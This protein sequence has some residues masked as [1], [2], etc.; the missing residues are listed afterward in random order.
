MYT[1]W[2]ST[3]RGEGRRESSGRAVVGDFFCLLSALRLT[4]TFAFGCVFCFPFV[5]IFF[6][7]AEKQPQQLYIL[8]MHFQFLWNGRAALC[9]FHTGYLTPHLLL[10]MHFIFTVSLCNHSLFFFSGG[11][12]TNDECDPTARSHKCWQI[13]IIG[14]TSIR[15][16]LSIITANSDGKCRNMACLGLVL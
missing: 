3:G 13:G 11:K 2:G 9:T 5:P 7:F 16:V 15:F 14:F 6:A 1:I 12:T 10:V 8:W 4:F